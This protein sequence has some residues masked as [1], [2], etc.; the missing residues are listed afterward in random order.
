M[1]YYLWVPETIVALLRPSGCGKTT[2][3]KM[4]SE[5]LIRLI[6]ARYLSMMRAY[7]DERASKV[8]SIRNAKIGYIFRDF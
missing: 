3:L 2:L 8:D 5:D 6:R 1:M 7:Q 4:L